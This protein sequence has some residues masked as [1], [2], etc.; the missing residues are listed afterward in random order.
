MTYL[1]PNT[2]N[3]IIL[4]GKG[5]N[6]EENWAWREGKRK[7]GIGHIVRDETQKLPL[8]N[9]RRDCRCHLLSKFD[10]K[11]AAIECM[12]GTSTLMYVYRV[13]YIQF[14]KHWIYQLNNNTLQFVAGQ[15]NAKKQW[16]K[17]IDQKLGKAS[18]EDVDDAG[19]ESTCS[20]SFFHSHLNSERSKSIILRLHTNTGNVE[21]NRKI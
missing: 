4:S 10:A 2:Y 8:H 21:T 14:A 3:R 18:N 1:I 7:N 12:L 16:K 17:R 5:I 9:A 19:D 13:L 6:M 20:N 15:K 11:S